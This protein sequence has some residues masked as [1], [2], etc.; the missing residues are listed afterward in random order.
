MIVLCNKNQAWGIKHITLVDYGNVAMSN[1]VRQSL[2]NFDHCLN[3]GRAKAEAAAES[4]RC[5]LPG[6]V[7]DHPSFPLLAYIFPS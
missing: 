1:P 2:Y 3:G 6:V 5:I 7:V 4:L